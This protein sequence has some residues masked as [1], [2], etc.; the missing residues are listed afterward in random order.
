MSYAFPGLKRLK[1]AFTKSKKTL[2][3]VTRRVS[4]TFR[5]SRK[6]RSRKN[7]SKKHHKKTYRGGGLGGP[8]KEDKSPWAGKRRPMFRGPIGGSRKKSLK[9]SNYKKCVKS[10]NTKKNKTL[11]KLLQKITCNKSKNKK[12]CKKKFMKHWKKGWKKGCLKKA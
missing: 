12:T 11:A 4:R 2:R 5:G 3:K 7:V 6:N 8:N 1:K 10:M 9:S